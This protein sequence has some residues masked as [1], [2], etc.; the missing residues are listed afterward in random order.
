MSILFLQTFNFAF[1]N[2]LKLI[3]AGAGQSII[4]IDVFWLSPDLS[5]SVLSL[6]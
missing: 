6:W 2:S 3:L 5:S 1:K 4:L